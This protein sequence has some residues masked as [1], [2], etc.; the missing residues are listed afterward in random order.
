[1]FSHPRYFGWQ[2]I[3]LD[4]PFK[5]GGH[6]LACIRHATIVRPVV[7]VVQVNAENIERPHIR[8]LLLETYPSESNRHCC[9]NQ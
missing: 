8:P 1:M 7:E 3:P 4:Q 5:K 6:F 9:I 2:V